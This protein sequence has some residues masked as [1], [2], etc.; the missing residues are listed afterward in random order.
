MRASSRDGGQPTGSSSPRASQPERSR[1]P[2][3]QRERE[4]GG[5][6]G[7][8][9][10]CR[11]S[12]G[13]APRM[14]TPQPRPPGPAHAGSWDVLGSP[15]AEARGVQFLLTEGRK[16]RRV[17]GAFRTTSEIL[18]LSLSSSDWI[19]K[20]TELERTPGCPA[21]H[22]VDLPPVFCF[23]FSKPELKQQASQ[24]SKGCSQPHCV[25]S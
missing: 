22:P 19:F 17:S 1:P 13:P 12:S 11:G 24:I 21:F 16:I 7:G 23:F 3:R 14:G 2:G 18:S 5:E 20:T 4:V 10:G 9:R 15:P 25:S 6:R 8:G